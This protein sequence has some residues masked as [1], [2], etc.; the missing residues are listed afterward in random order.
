VRI[1][2]AF[3]PD[4]DLHIWSAKIGKDSIKLHG[5]RQRFVHK[6]LHILALTPRT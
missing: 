5:D 2:A 6:A 1:D 3:G 4:N